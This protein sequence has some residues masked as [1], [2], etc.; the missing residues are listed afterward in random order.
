MSNPLDFHRQGGARHRGRSRHGA[1][2]RK[3]FR[4]DE[5]KLMKEEHENGI[6][7]R[8]VQSA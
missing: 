4:R 1:S 5:H 6:R 3:A 2:D 7:A 8:Y